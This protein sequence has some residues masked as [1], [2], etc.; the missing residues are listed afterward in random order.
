[1]NPTWDGQRWRIRVMQDGKSHSFSCKTPGPKGRKEVL[2]LY[3]EWLYNEGTG[4]KTFGKV[5]EEY[6]EDLAARNGKTSGS[7]H[8]NECYI[9]LYIAPKIASKKMYKITLREYQSLINEACGADG[10]PLSYKTLSNIRSI[11][12]G[13]VKFGYA[14]FQC[15]MLRGDLYIPKGR[16]RHEKV[17]LQKADIIRLFE[18]SESELWYLNAYRLA[19]ITGLRPGELIGL[20]T[21][22]IDWKK[23]C[24]RIRRAVN[25]RRIE[26]EG[27]NKNARRTVPIGQ[28]ARQILEETI[29]RNKNMNLRTEWIFCSEDGSVGNQNTLGKQW[30]RLRKEKDFPED[31][32]LYCLRHTF[33][34]MTKNVLPEGMLK[35]LL[36]HSETMDTYGTYAHEVDGEDNKKTA[37]IIDLT[38]NFAQDLPKTK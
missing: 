4:E 31:V 8:Q 29:E 32:S 30:R 3:N 25:S 18:P 13:I 16:Q 7:Y 6:L 15:E 12:M 38:F 34:S 19:V 1:M 11:I 28:T 37:E 22:D 21:S 23:D 9:R 33:V 2:R 17:I 35:S 27:K 20:K 24:I 36:G 10:E 26:T 5:C 14:D